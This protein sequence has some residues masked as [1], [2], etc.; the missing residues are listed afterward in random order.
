MNMESCTN[1]WT[2]MDCVFEVDE[3]EIIKERLRSLEVRHILYCSFESRFAK[4]GGL[5]AV[6]AKILP[7][8]RRLEG[9]DSAGL[10]TPFYPDII[11]EKLDTTGLSFEI[12]F[13][14][15]AVPVEIL[16][17][18]PNPIGEKDGDVSEFYLRAPG[19]FNAVDNN[20]YLYDREDPG[21][22]HSAI[23][24]NA[25]FFCKA[26][27][28]AL[29]KLGMVRNVVLHLQEWQTTLLA[30]TV[31]EAMLSPD[32]LYNCGTVQTLHNPFDCGIT[33]E[34]LEMISIDNRIGRHRNRISDKPELCGSVNMGTPSAF[35]VGLQLTDGPITTVSESFSREL[36]GDLLQTQHFA[37]HLQPIFERS[38]VCGVNNGLF[39]DFP[40]EYSRKETYS[41]PEIRS[42]KE[43]KRRALLDI[44]SR[45]HPKE[46]FGTLTWKGKSIK[47]LPDDVPI[48]VMSGRLDPA[49]KGYDIL[50]RALEKF[51]PGQVKT[52]L[53]PMATRIPDLDYFYEVAL[54]C[55]GDL[56]VFPGRME[57][58][59][60]ELQ[61]GAAFGLMPS[62]Y[63]PFGAAVE[64]MVNGTAVIARET[65]GLKDQIKHNVSGLLFRE[66]IESCT[67][68]DIKE[69]SQFGDIVQ[70]R[71]RNHWAQS[72]VQALYRVMQEAVDI[73]RNRQEDYY[74]LIAAGF[75]QAE[76]FDWQ[77]G[78]EEYH[79]VYSRIASI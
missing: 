44:L 32:M 67:L 7:Y 1:D 46:R 25:L 51:E 3:I 31:K 34:M 75:R 69:F 28:A 39:V 48:F 19:F 11:G 54:K 45:Y 42:I 24:K 33:Q 56:T 12:E 79:R 14:G 52:I 57:K 36:T 13:A 26:V 63:E 70:M 43:E 72:M 61:M 53:T 35:Q 15:Q 9:V 62:I 41:L 76:L 58:G 37:P 71:K 10:I 21:H 17:Y 68:D 4:S 27:P 60:R 20:P 18:K 22:N 65:G 29:K 38:G 49:Q 30:L 47:H 64:Y 5:G 77:T 23:R 74:R 55:K 66:A 6:T 59:Y 50:L 16:V 40:P 2:L 8:L 78:A 73:F